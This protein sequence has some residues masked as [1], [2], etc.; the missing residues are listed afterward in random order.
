MVGSIGNLRKETHGNY[1]GA[2]YALASIHDGIE[3][4]I[5]RGLE[6]E[7]RYFLKA[8]HS[9]EAKNIIRTGFFFVNEAKK[10]K[11]KPQGHDFHAV[12]K[13]GVL[14]AGM[15]GAGI[16]YVSA[17][18][19]MEVALKDVS[20]EAAERGRRH[21]AELL[22]KRVAK[23]RMSEEE[24]AA[25]LARIHPG[26]EPAALA[27]ADLV[28][29]AVFEDPALKARVTQETEA[30]LSPAAIFGSN[31]STLPISM[32]AQASQRPEN[33]IGIHFFSPVDKMPLVEIIVGERTAERTIAAAVFSLHGSSALLPAKR[34]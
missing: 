4:P 19:G 31:T 23:G 7:A 12:K 20:L 10:G 24:A 6:V 9:P 14:G 25:I 2:Q 18:A 29:E 33:F 5:E 15:M 8:I 16:A 28:V 32:L 27:G 17:L 26:D 22:R 3:L 13:L 34:R 30:V 1:P 21:A 11:A